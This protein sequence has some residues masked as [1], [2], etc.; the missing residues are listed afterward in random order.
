[1]GIGAQQFKAGTINKRITTLNKA[2]HQAKALRHKAFR[3]RHT[4]SALEWFRGDNSGVGSRSFQV[5]KI[6]LVYNGFLDRSRLLPAF[7]RC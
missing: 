7:R 1:M 6:S 3:S 5:C 2:C 4:P